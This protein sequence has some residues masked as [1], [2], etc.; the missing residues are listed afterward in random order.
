MS[1]RLGYVLPCLLLVL[2]ACAVDGDIDDASNP[3]TDGTPDAVGVL[4]LLN[5][6]STTFAVLDIDAGLDRRAAAGLID[7]RNGPDGMFGTADDQPFTS[8]ADVDRVR[9]VGQSALNKL[10]SYS[11]DNGFV[12]DGNAVF[13]VFDGVTFT[14]D[15]AAATLDLVNTASETVL[16]NDVKLDKR[17][18]ESILDARPVADM[19]TLASLYYVGKAMLTR[20]RD[21]AAPIQLGII[22]D[23]DKT[24]IPPHGDELPAAPYAGVATLYNAIDDGG[25][26][27]VYYVTAR[28]EDRVTEIPAWLDAQ[29]VPAGLI[30][31]GISP[32]PWVAKDEKVRDILSVFDANPGQQF[33]MFGDTNHVDADAFRVVME[34]RPEQVVA[35]FVHNVKTIDADRLEGLHVF[36]DHRSVA[37]RL[38]ELGV[39]D[40]ATADAI[41]TEV[42]SAPE[43]L[44]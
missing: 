21:F 29:G 9:W 23:L 5:S 6:A 11:R 30:H 40:S 16:R 39:I 41:H 12:P 22:S 25:A 44:R 13:G 28:S 14:F 34:L 42:A 15:Q 4:A 33:V 18:V 17:A 3:L 38:A 27:D 20:A 26:S 19:D 32:V 43:D 8:V 35:A 7:R 2:G 37:T 10:I 36:E 1:V 24:V 31:T